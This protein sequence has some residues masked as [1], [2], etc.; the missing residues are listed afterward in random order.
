MVSTTYESQLVVTS[1]QLSVFRRLRPALST[2]HI[3]M[4]LD[5][6]YPVFSDQWTTNRPHAIT[7]LVKPNLRWLGR[8]YDGC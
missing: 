4:G 7:V 5:R 1:F 6:L 2:G 8:S 3:W